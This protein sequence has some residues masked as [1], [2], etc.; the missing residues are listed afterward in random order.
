MVREMHLEP[1]HQ[2]MDRF[3]LLAPRER[4]ST[5]HASLD[6]SHGTVPPPHRHQNSGPTNLP[7]RTS[8][9]GTYPSSPATDIW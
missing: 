8:D 1:A 5:S 2:R 9:L 4:V 6:K 3:I 7:P